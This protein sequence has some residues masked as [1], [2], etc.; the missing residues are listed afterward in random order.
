MV[1]PRAS[2]LSI[3][4][5]DPFPPSFMHFYT[6]KVLDSLL[7]DAYCVSDDVLEFMSL[8]PVIIM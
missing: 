3:G 8:W 7:L 6:T 4:R 5:K 1:Q 2:C